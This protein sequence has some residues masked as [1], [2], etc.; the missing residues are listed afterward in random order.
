[1]TGRRYGDVSM[2]GRAS[3]RALT[4]RDPATAPGADVWQPTLS[5]GR[6]DAGASKDA[7][8]PA[9]R[10]LAF[11]SFRRWA[12]AVCG[13]CPVCVE[14]SHF[15]GE[16]APVRRVQA[17]H[18]P[19]KH[20]DYSPFAAGGAPFVRAR[21][22]L[23][24]AARVTGGYLARNV[25]PH[26]DNEV[27]ELRHARRYSGVIGG[28]ELL[29]CSRPDPDDARHLVRVRALGGALSNQDLG[30][31]YRVYSRIVGRQRVIPVLG[32]LRLEVEG[33]MRGGPAV[34]DE[35]RH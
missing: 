30:Q 24:S 19:R 16:L 21:P 1:V 3:G 32:Q 2:A 22:Q 6:A 25:F 4:V 9:S 14:N 34:E 35:D 12:G 17:R 20:H 15:A 11:C 8:G 29:N 28:G 33:A 27:S 7:K 5:A 23:A 31:L 26:K 18:Y 10:R 13:F